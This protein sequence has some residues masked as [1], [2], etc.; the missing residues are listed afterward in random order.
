MAEMKENA[1]KV[2]FNAEENGEET[3]EKMKSSAKNVQLT[4][5]D[6]L[7][8]ANK[9]DFVLEKEIDKLIP[10][11][12]HPFQIKE[13]EEM[14]KLVKS[15][16]EQGVVVPGIARPIDG[17]YFEL[18]AGHRRRYACMKLGIKTM[19]VLIKRLDDDEAT[20]AMVDS[21]LQREH[22]LPSE[23]AFS[24]KMKLEAIKH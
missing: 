10:F 18:I 5:F 1:E 2:N 21:N 11:Q 15:I 12:G 24:Y 3:K 4:S 23:R 19:P 7:F 9:M 8:Y 20:I 16:E 6:E 13:D 22:I 17:E 14:E